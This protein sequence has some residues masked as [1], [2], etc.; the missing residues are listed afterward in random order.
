MRTWGGQ[1]TQ[2]Y[3]N[4]LARGRVGGLML[5][6]IRPP[7]KDVTC[8][9]ELCSASCGA[10]CVHAGGGQG[11]LPGGRSMSCT[12]KGHR[13]GGKWVTQALHFPRFPRK[14]VGVKE[15]I[16]TALGLPSPTSASSYKAKS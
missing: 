12:L 16:S 1:R 5:V 15:R 10:P 2:P 9:G 3:S 8:Q 11:R 6:G 13:S 7:S 4:S 14:Y